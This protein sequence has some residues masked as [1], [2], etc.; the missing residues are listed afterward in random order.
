MTAKNLVALEFDNLATALAAFRSLTLEIAMTPVLTDNIT[1]PV[2]K[3]AIDAERF[4][5]SLVDRLGA[6]VAEAGQSGTGL[7]ALPDPDDIK[8]PH[9]YVDVYFPH[10]VADIQR[11][12]YEA[13]ERDS[14]IK[15][16]ALGAPSDI[17]VVE[18][19]NQGFAAGFAK[20]EREA[21]GAD[22][23]GGQWVRCTP[24]LLNAGVSCA[25]TPRRPGDG[26]YSHDHW[27]SHVNLAT[28]KVVP[29]APTPAM[30]RAAHDAENCGHGDKHF[31]NAYLAMIQAAASPAAVPATTV[32]RG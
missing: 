23:G 22:T 18:A 15:R 19:H 2:Y 8:G 13:G 3:A 1:H 5:G 32:T 30:L 24:N 27:I 11:E 31:A 25:H 17:D 29:L 28:H 20:A 9:G 7:P 21:S 26:S 4:L 6:V 10:T 14:I 16:I 12:A